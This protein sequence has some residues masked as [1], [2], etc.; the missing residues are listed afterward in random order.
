[1]TNYDL[2]FEDTRRPRREPL[3]P[4]WQHRFYDAAVVTEEQPEARLY[5]PRYGLIELRARATDDPRAMVAPMRG[6]RAQAR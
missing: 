4:Y 1:M 5:T 3:A 2:E 6:Y